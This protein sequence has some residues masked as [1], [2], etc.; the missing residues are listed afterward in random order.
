M[1]PSD[2]WDMEMT[3]GQV[4]RQL[5]HPLAACG[6][7]VREAAVLLAGSGTATHGDVRA[8]PSPKP[9]DQTTST[10]TS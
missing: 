6:R 3:A 10:G 8:S 5:G 1:E 4:A 2:G 9:P 7:S